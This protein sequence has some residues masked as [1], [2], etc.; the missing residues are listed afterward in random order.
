[1]IP[2]LH[3]FDAQ[4]P[5]PERA[6]SEPNGLLAIG[7]DLSPQRLLAAYREGIFPW[8]SEGDPILWWSP[9]P[10]M[11]LVPGDLRISRSFSKRLRN[12]VYEVRLDTA[13]ERVI[14]ECAAPRQGQSGTWIT[15]SMREAYLSL[16]RSGYAHSAETW[17]EGELAGGLY[18]V[19]IGDIFFGESMFS[20]AND[21]SKLALARL[22]GWLR[23]ERFHLIDCQFHTDHLQSLGAHRIARRDFLRLVRSL[24]HNPRIAGSWSPMRFSNKPCRN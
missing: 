18:G 21:A 3:T 8:F 19:A 15:A 24:V 5:S 20:R 6:L 14:D 22:A 12:S 7:G 2:F 11:V 1:L 9:D 13:F 4:F 17:I 10:R 16:H 23:A